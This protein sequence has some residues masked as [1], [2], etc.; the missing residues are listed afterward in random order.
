MSHNVHPKVYRLRTNSD[1]DSRWFD[2]KHPSKYLEEDFRIRQ[3]LNN[4]LKDAGIEK[5]EIERSPNSTL[6]IISTSRPGLIIGRG[7]EQVEQIK[8]KLEQ[9]ILKDREKKS[10]LKLEVKSIKNPWLSAGL[11][12]QWVAQRIEKRM[13][14]R[15]I[16]KQAVSTAESYKDVKGIRVQ[17]SGR[18]NGV[19]ISR[20]EWVQQGNLPRNTL[21]ADIDYGFS[22]AHCTYG[23]IGVKAWVYKGE[24]FDN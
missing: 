23:I 12:S 13:P 24:K 4:T 10:E 22:E 2:D 8:N 14:F 15:K 5:I 9:K 20:T 6:I 19:T 16:I 3:F 21:R 17:V 7:G 18:L 11:I 1:W